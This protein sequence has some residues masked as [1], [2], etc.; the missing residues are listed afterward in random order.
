MD[1]LAIIGIGI[2]AILVVAAAY[3]LYTGA[4]AEQMHS[5]AD[6]EKLISDAEDAIEK[7]EADGNDASTAHMALEI[8]KRYFSEGDYDSA[9]KYASNAIEF[10]N[11]AQPAKIEEPPPVPDEFFG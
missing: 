6:A 4:A 5:K 11:S 2:V 7:S 8:A 1:T 9:Y 3:V 10:A